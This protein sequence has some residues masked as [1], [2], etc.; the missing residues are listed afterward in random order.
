MP[1]GAGRRGT[2]TDERQLNT[3]GD[4]DLLPLVLSA[5]EEFSDKCPSDEQ[6]NELVQRQSL[7]PLFISLSRGSRSRATT[8]ARQP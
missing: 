4:V 1:A 8:K 5:A 6:M 3:V 2:V 7:R